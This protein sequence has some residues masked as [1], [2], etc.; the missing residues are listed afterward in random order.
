MFRGPSRFSSEKRQIPIYLPG[1][2]AVLRRN[3]IASIDY[4]HR[5]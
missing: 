1:T 5:F 3:N 4:S 2:A